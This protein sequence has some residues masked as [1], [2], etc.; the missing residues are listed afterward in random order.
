ME[1]C[2]YCESCKGYL[3]STSEGIWHRIDDRLD[4]ISTIECA[5]CAEEI[6]V[7]EEYIFEHIDN[8]DL[9]KIEDEMEELTE[10][11]HI[12]WNYFD[13]KQLV[14]LVNHLIKKEKWNKNKVKEYLTKWGFDNS[15]IEK[16]VEVAMFE[17]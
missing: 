17:R 9:D 8:F 6:N 16:I 5:W 1:R 15:Y 4:G 2:Y 14:D 11:K 3:S 7:D 12:M 10:F 13:E